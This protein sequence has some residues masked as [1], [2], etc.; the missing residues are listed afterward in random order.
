MIKF[1]DT[2]ATPTA[3]HPQPETQTLWQ[4]YPN[5]VASSLTIAFN[6]HTAKQLSFCITN[7]AG[8]AVYSENK[9]NF[10][11]LNTTLDINYL[12]AGMYIL[13]VMVN[14]QKSVTK[15]LKQ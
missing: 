10:N 3:V 4:L 5:P 14:D 6:D 9:T 11:E 2:T 1:C 13:T 12:P 8:Q 7:L 15:L